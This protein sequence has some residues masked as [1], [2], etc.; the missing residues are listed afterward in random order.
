MTT[1]MKLALNNNNVMMAFY[2][3][4][5]KMQELNNLG[6]NITLA[7][8]CLGTGVGQMNPVISTQH[9]LMVW[10]YFINK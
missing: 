10:T 5:Q 6:A 3:I 4:L 9:I 1:P 8:S 2:A 7:C